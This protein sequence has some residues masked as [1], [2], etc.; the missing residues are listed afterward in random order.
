MLGIEGSSLPSRYLPKRKDTLLENKM[1]SRLYGVGKAWWKMTDQDLEKRCAKY[2]PEG[3]H[4]A[5]SAMIEYHTERLSRHTEPK[6]SQLFLNS[7]LKYYEASDAEKEEIAQYLKEDIISSANGFINS[8]DQALEGF[9]SL[10]SRSLRSAALICWGAAL[11]GGTVIAAAA[12][13]GDNSTASKIAMYAGT[14]CC[15]FSA[16]FGYSQH[17]SAKRHEEESNETKRPHY[18]ETSIAISDIHQTLQT[19]DYASRINT[20]LM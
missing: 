14:V 13:K 8:L 3:I 15:A 20:L 1:S 5:I 12:L 10:L 18:D 6:E 11:F 19:N 7:I 4:D 2:T 17:R 16:Y 9:D